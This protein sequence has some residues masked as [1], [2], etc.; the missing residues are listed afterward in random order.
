MASNETVETGG[1]VS[2]AAAGATISGAIV[3][4]GAVLA[5]S[6]GGLA[7]NTT[8]AGGTVVLQGP[9]DTLSGSFAFN[10]GGTLDVNAIAA[11]GAGDQA[12]ISGFYTGD[13]ITI[14]A[15]SAGATLSTT[16]SGG[17]TIATVSSVGVTE[18]LTFSGA[19]A[20][21]LSLTSSGGVSQID[22]A[23][24]PTTNSYTSGDLVLSIYGDG[25]GT[26]NYSLDQAAP[27][28]LEEITQSSQIVSDQE[29]P[30]TTHVVSGTTE[31]AISGKYESASEGLLTLA[32]NG[33]SLVI[34]G[35]GV[36]AT[37]F[38]A[39]NAASIYGTTA[40][41]QTTSILGGQ[42][43][44]VERVVADISY[45]TNVDT[46]TSLSDIF[47]TNNPRSVYT[48]NGT[49]FYLGGQGN[50]TDG[51]EG[52]FVANDGASTATP[53]HNTKTDVRQVVVYN[54]QLYV[55]IE[56]KLNGGAGLY[57]FGA[58]LPTGQ[59]APIELPGIGASIT[60]TAAQANS[61][62]SAAI[63]TSVNLSPEQYFFANP[64]TLY[65]AD[66]GDPK[67]G[68]LGDG[69][70]QKWSLVSGTW[71]LDYTL[72]LGL[73][74]V[75]DTDSDGTT[76]LVGLTGT[77]EG[78]NVVLYATNETVA[79]TDQ[80]YLYTITDPLAATTAPSNES[81]TLLDTAAPDTLIRGVAFAPN[82]V[83]HHPGGLHSVDGVLRGDVDGIIDHHGRYAHGEDRRYHCRHHPVVRWIGVYFGGRCRLRDL[84]RAWR[85]RSGFRRCQLRHHR[86][87]AKRQQ[88]HGRRHQRSDRKRRH[89]GVVQGR[90][91]RQ[92][93][94]G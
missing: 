51:T 65:I 22:Y 40:L 83:T 14:S 70:L 15:I 18:T 21:N 41:G 74:Q 49:V 68:G 52:V 94:D 10:G 34:A 75:P 63:G 62:N 44:A 37:N 7:V 24:P 27:I 38:D 77:V 1:N 61:V 4:S 31:Y 16:S 47:N 6:G 29:L 85:Q 23:G 8:V 54:G 86:R 45:N 17:N 89:A 60:L 87:R 42:Y 73:N 32:G 90:R 59:T 33:Q 78:S 91:Q 92:R 93:H 82:R 11:Q 72:S 56:S 80:T 58:T 79:E 43:T 2:L 88:R 66:G 36:T 84:Y 26:G 5:L 53:I 30:Q 35:Y 3:S 55:S 20:S 48:V 64:T 19:V 67:E 39:A 71:V 46:S 25:S 57:D 76:G 9:T 28:T 69:G 50:G 12:V 13:V 81:F